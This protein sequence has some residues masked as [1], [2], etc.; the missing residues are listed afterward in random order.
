MTRIHTQATLLAT[1][2][3]LALLAPADADGQEVRAPERRAAAVDMVLTLGEVEPKGSPMVMSWDQT[4]AST[5]RASRRGPDGFHRP[6]PGPNTLTVI[7]PAG[8]TSQALSRAHEEGTRLPTAT[9]TVRPRGAPESES[10]MTIDMYDVGVE[11]YTRAGDTAARVKLIF[12][13][14]TEVR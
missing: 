7:I 13:R 5:W 3:A 2:F 14:S 10:I 12:P 4:L 1:A 6:L 8:P 11:S 9:L